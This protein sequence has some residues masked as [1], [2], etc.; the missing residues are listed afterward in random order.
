MGMEGLLDW[1]IKEWEKYTEAP[2]VM[3]LKWYHYSL[4]Y[5]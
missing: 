1:L 2:G 3:F 4:S 5:A